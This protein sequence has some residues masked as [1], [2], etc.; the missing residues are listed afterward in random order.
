M[1]ICLLPI[2][3]R[4]SQNGLEIGMP[5]LESDFR[6]LATDARQ[7]AEE[8][9]KLRKINS[10]MIS[11]LENVLPLLQQGLPATVDFDWT[12]EAVAKVQ[13]RSPKRSATDPQ[14]LELSLTPRMVTV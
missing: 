4:F 13:V 11:V 2:D 10:Q 12:K 5:D 3:G 8:N 9:A 1:L 7:M 14:P 6:K